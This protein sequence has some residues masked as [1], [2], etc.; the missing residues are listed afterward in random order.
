MNLRILWNEVFEKDVTSE[1]NAVPTTVYSEK[2]EYGD[3][4]KIIKESDR[5]DWNMIGHIL[6]HEN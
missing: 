2:Q 4:V 3:I 5:Y 1:L 6:I